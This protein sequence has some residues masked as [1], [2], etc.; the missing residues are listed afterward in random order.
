MPDVTWYEPTE[1]GLEA[2]I[3]EKL[4]CA[5]RA[6][7]GDGRQ[8]RDRRTSDATS[9]RYRHDCLD[10]CST[11]R[12]CRMLDIK[13]LATISPPS[14]P[15]SPSAASRSTPRASRRSSAS[16]RGCR[17]A[18]RSCRRSATRCRSRSAPQGQGR[19]CLGAA[20]R[21]RRHRRRAE[22][23]E[24]RAR[25]RAGAAARL[26]ARRCRTSRTRASPV[27]HVGRRQRRGAPLGHAARVRL[28]G[29]GP[30][31]PRRGARAARFRHGGQALGRALLVPARRPRAPAPRARAVHARHA[32]ARARLHRV[33]HAVHR[34]RRE[35]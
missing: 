21:G 13:L 25:P 19:G 29:Q 22:G 20:R 14:P 27:G 4:A 15:A 8:A 3:R 5:A 16:A 31:R 26:P 18:R 9:D 32:H 28:P 6:R 7:R 34:Q 10:A 33:L 30:R 2:K 23:L 12:I 11:D 1:R 35:R 24:A 17:R